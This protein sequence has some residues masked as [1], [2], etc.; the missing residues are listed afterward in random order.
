MACFRWGRPVGTP[1]VPTADATP[2]GRGVDGSRVNEILAWS[3]WDSRVGPRG[4]KISPCRL[5]IAGSDRA[6]EKGG[7]KYAIPI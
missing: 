1:R 6:F 2:S 3:V 7:V 4:G 5:P